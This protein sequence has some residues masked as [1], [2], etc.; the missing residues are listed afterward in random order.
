LDSPEP[1]PPLADE[2]RLV[3]SLMP[4]YMGIYFRPLSDGLR[5]RYRTGRGA[6]SIN[7]VNPDSPAAEPAS[8]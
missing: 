6:V 8:R 5:K 2:E 4:A 3:E 7:N 1:F